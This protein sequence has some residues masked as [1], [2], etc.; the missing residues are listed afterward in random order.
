MKRALLLMLACSGAHA[1]FF[2]GNDLLSKLN[3]SSYIDQSMAMGYV[4]GVS[5]TGTRVTHCPPRHATVGQVQDMVRYHLE[6][7]PSSRHF[8]ADSIIINLLKA[9][10]PCANRQGGTNL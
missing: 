7:N 4:A 8:T 2:T 10:W 5:D 1:E 6:S 9:T 3:S